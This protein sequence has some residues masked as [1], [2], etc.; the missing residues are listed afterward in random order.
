MMNKALRPLLGLGLLLCGV[1]VDA[2]VVMDAR[3]TT[4]TTGA[5]HTK[6]SWTTLDTSTSDRIDYILISIH[7]A[8]ANSI[9]CDLGTGGAGSEAVI[10]ADVGGNIAGA[11]YTKAYAF[12]AAV[13]SGSRLSARCQT[14]VATQSV[15]M[16]VFGYTRQ[17]ATT[18]NVTTYG[19]SRDAEGDDADTLGI[20]IDPGA[21]PDTKGAYVDFGALSANVA[22]FWVYI[23][24]NGD[25]ARAAASNQF[26]D[27]G[28]G[29]A[30]DCSSVTLKTNDLFVRYTVA[31]DE[32]H[33]IIGPFDGSMTSGN[34][35]CVR[36]ESS[37]GTDSDRDMDV[38]VYTHTE[39]IDKAAGGG[40]PA[41]RNSIITGGNCIS[42]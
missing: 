27:V 14:N 21:T 23:G 24:G 19:T 15:V 33:D 9:L 28:E 34:H 3:T 26:I 38:I 17:Q 37:V 42:P 25:T 2:V 5:A 10:I 36:G 8:V 30:S 7:T 11:G 16:Q 41:C 35:L 4:I 13:P 39:G 40:G 18:G 12:N 32:D 20:N 31:L 6:G 1:T 22:S 29:G